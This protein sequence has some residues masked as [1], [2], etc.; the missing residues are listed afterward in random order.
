MLAWSHICCTFLRRLRC[1]QPRNTANTAA[2]CADRPLC[3]ALRLPFVV[4]MHAIGCYDAVDCGN[5][6]A[7][8]GFGAHKTADPGVSRRFNSGEALEQIFSGQL[9]VGILGKENLGWGACELLLNNLGNDMR[10]N[11]R[12]SCDSD[13]G[14]CVRIGGALWPCAS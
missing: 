6:Y 9:V 14:R 7:T 5:P 4:F 1:L 11:D 3:A 12:P 13:G 8:C 2:G 10:R